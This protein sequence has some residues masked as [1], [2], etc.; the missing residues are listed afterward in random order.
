VG[1]AAALS[2]QSIKG[3]GERADPQDAIGVLVDRADLA[4]RETIGFAGTMGVV[5]ESCCRRSRMLTPPLTVPTQSS[6]TDRG[7]SPRTLL[8]LRLS[9]FGAIVLKRASHV[10]CAGRSNESPRLDGTQNPS[11]PSSTNVLLSRMAAPA[12]AGT[13]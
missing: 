13:R 2:I 12:R 10:P 1:D 4:G 8:S 5:A 6:P 3:A 11:P 7:R 9:G